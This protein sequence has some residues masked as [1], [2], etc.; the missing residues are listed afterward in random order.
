MWIWQWTCRGSSRRRRSARPRIL[1]WGLWPR[2]TLGLPVSQAL[3]VFSTQP[4][5]EHDALPVRPV[6]VSARFRGN[7]IKS[8]WTPA[9][10]DLCWA[11]FHNGVASALALDRDQVARVHAS[12]VLLNRPADEPVGLPGEEDKVRDHRLLRASHAGVLLGLG[13]AGAGPLRTLPP[14]QAFQYLSARDGLTSVGFLLGTACAAQG[15]G[16]AQAAK[17]LSLHIPSL[18]PAGASEL[19]LLSHGTRAAAMLGLGLVYA[20]SQNRRMVEVALRELSM[21]RTAP[22]EDHSARLDD[23]DPAE[24]SRECYALSAGFALGLLVLGQGQRTE[25]LADLNLLDTLSAMVGRTVGAVGAESERTGRPGS[26]MPSAHAMPGVSDLGPVAALGLAFLGTN[27][28]PAAHRLALPSTLQLLRT[29]DPFV[30]L[31]KTLMRCLIMADA[32]TPTAAWIE[33]TVPM[34]ESPEPDLVRARLHIT[35][36]ACFA[37]AIKHAGSE[38]AMALQTLLQYFDQLHALAKRPAAGYEARLTRASA[39]ACL[40]ILCISCALVMAGSGNIEVMRRLRCLHAATPM[41]SYGDHMASHMALGLLFLGGGARL[42]LSL[43][44]L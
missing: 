25:T 17:L 4:L 30:L 22:A 10:P 37:L 24:S 29:T 40:N 33:S 27:Y 43:Q 38:D 34:P 7:R 35:S 32:I 9:E 1:T 8:T 42:T 23:A 20:R 2:R 13:L 18:L 15:T 26:A 19:M 31:W 36:A 6:V 41:R 3:L 11:Q 14:W 28:R 44:R 12:W 21:C 5:N 16:D 39:Q